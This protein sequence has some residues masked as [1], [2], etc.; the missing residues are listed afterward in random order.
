MNVGDKIAI[1][2]VVAGALLGIVESPWYFVGCGA[3]ALVVGIVA[4]DH[5]LRAR[6]AAR[7]EHWRTPCRAVTRPSPDP[8]AQ[9]LGVGNSLHAQIE[10]YQQSLEM[11]AQ[12]SILHK[13][14]DSPTAG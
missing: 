6:Q 2:L 9:P 14:D 10:A 7:R 1:L 4:S 3:L 8:T 13:P 5:A 12:S 11:D